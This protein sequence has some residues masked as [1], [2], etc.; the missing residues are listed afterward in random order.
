VATA[1][2]TLT[3]A[4]PLLVFNLSDGGSAVAATVNAAGAGSLVL[5]LA[6]GAE[7][8]AALGITQH[9][10]SRLRDDTAPVALASNVSADANGG[11]QLQLARSPWGWTAVLY[12]NNGIT[13]Q[14]NAPA[15]VD[16]TAG[17]AVTLTLAPAAGVLASAWAQ[18]GARAPRQPLAVAAGGAV[19]VEVEAGGL[20]IVGL[21]L[22]D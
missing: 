7:A 6:P 16:V 17:R 12:N 3:T 10:L 8:A 15:V 13:K 14:P 9:I 2:A 21:V 22:A 11:V 18:D 5:L 4:A 19:T 20:R 1:A